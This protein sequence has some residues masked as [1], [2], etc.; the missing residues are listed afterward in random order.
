MLIADDSGRYVAVNSAAATLLGYEQSQ[1][2][3][4]RAHDIAAPEMALEGAWEAFLRAGS[5]RG[6]FAALTATGD[7][8]VLDSPR[9]RTSRPGAT[10]RSCAT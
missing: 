6:E 5:A 10:C 3:G 2:I 9:S 7:R 4:K 8:R 1:L